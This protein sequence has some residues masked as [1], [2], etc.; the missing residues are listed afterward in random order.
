[1]IY[2]FNT[3]EL[4]TDNFCLKN[5]GLNVPIE[6][7]VFNL[8]VYL[9]NNRDKVVT[10]DELFEKIWLG[11]VVSDATLSNHINSARTLLG[12]DGVKQ[13]VIKTIRGRGYQFV[14]QLTP[15]SSNDI[16]NDAAEREGESK[17]K[18][19]TNRFLVPSFIICLV[20]VCIGGGYFLSQIQKQPLIQSNL[21]N[22]SSQ[23]TI[24]VI[25]FRVV[26]EVE[27]DNIF[28]EGF[29]GELTAKLSKISDIK[30]ISHLSVGVYLQQ[31][32]NSDKIGSELNASHLL[33]GS[34]QRA[35]DQ[36]KI[37]IQLIEVNSNEHVWAE[38]YT[39][40]LNL[41]NMFSVQ[42]DITTSITEH[43]SLVLKNKHK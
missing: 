3:Y 8:I 29:C 13:A 20:T 17:L 15:C 38:S 22:I 2:Q 39:R 36:V 33:I 25:P 18:Q 40:D 35:S 42:S 10:R 9:I 11:R 26:S 4:D 41:E 19:S 24:A 30:I 21:D 37:S 16:S 14:A 6:P 34:M 32:K 28:I 7:Q 23:Q 12:D 1:M 31:N 43:L 5:S 27:N